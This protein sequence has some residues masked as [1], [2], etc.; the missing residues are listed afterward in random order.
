MLT[1]IWAVLI[2]SKRNLFQVPRVIGAHGKAP[3]ISGDPKDKGGSRG[4]SQE[5]SASSDSA[6]GP[7]QQGVWGDVSD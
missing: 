7:W 2:I 1:G 6:L 3:G 4:K 5:K